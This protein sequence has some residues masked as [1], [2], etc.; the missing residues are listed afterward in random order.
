[1][2]NSRDDREDVVPENPN[3][4]DNVSSNEADSSLS[5]DM[6]GAD[7][8]TLRMR[9]MHHQNNLNIT[10]FITKELKSI[11]EI[12]EKAE[13]GTLTEGETRAY[14]EYR[15]DNDPKNMVHDYDE[16][17]SFLDNIN[18]EI[19]RNEE[20][21]EYFRERIE[22]YRERADQLEREELEDNSSSSSGNLMDVDF[23]DENSD[24]E[25]SNEN[26]N[27]EEY[28]QSPTEYVAELESTLPGDFIGGGDD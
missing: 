24:T 8:D 4:E 13:S 27:N 5:T 11:K 18:S 15:H 16:N 14:E 26:N 9:S 3:N 20:R 2:S 19:T 17:K 25:D 1:M 22:L 7:V 10:Q 23:D 28:N 6:E 12:T 21:L